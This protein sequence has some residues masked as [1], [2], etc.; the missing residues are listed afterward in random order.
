MMNLFRCV[1]LDD[2][3]L[4]VS[5][6]EAYVKQRPE[7]Q[8]AATFTD[9]IAALKYL[10]TQHCDLLFLDIQMPDLS[11]IQVMKIL[12]GQTQIILSTAYPEFALEGFEHNAAD[13]LLKP[14]SRERFDR[15]V[16]KFL[17]TVAKKEMRK[18]PD[19]L[20][21]KSEHRLLKVMLDDILWLE[22]MR[23]YVAIHHTQG[24]KILT[25]QSL[26]SFEEMLPTD[27]FMRIHKSYIVALAKISFVERNRVFVQDHPLPVSDSH[28][29]AFML[30][31][32]GG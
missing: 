26:R 28:R 32:K 31:I 2:E 24:K 21:V 18:A 1:I 22:A 13:Y 6:M 5:L 4:A 19:F 7:L 12:H 23:D 15:G 29:T 25:L 8:L 10:Q 27:A 17:S 9:A 16:D 11:G 3:P 30:R 20:F 14:V